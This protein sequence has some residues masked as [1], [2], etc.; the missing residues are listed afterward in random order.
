MRVVAAQDAGHAPEGVGDHAHFFDAGSR[1]RIKEVV[2]VPDMLGM[3]RAR[4]AKGGLEGSDQAGRS[5]FDRFD[6]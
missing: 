6:L 1:V 5:A 2:I 3:T 4:R